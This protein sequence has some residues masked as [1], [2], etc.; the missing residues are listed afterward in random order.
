M[1]DYYSTLGVTRTATEDEIKKSYR[2]LA[3]QFHP[4]RNKDNPKAEEKFKE[5]SEAYAVL[6]DKEKRAQYDQVGH[7]RFSQSHSSED[8]FRGADFHQIFDDFGLGDDLFSR[9]FGAMGGAGGRGGFGQQSA[10]R[11]PAPGQDLEYELTIGFMEAYQGGERKISFKHGSVHQDFQLKIPAGVQNGS[12]LRVAG[13]GGASPSGQSA[14]GDLYVK[15]TVAENP[16]FR[17]QGADIEVDLPLKISE[18]L[19]GCKTEVETPEGK[20]IITV[21]AGM[22]VGKKIRLKGLGFPHKIGT[23]GRGD[24]YALIS[25]H[26]PKDLTHQQKE[27]I[28]QLRDSGL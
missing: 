27:L 22:M 6:S 5:I 26:I 10:H 2:K 15:I 14:A 3:L 20:K 4:D 16:N 21:P 9:I 11:P 25:F 28:E 7:N 13:K 1:A 17:R 23:K 24:L 12:K 18:A 8:I 19:L